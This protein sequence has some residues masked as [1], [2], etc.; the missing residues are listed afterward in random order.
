MLS[1]AS[2]SL[3]LRFGEAELPGSTAIRIKL[4][5]FL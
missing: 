2:L 3:T 5:G 4:K 1:L